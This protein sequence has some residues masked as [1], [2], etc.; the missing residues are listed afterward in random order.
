[1]EQG[2]GSTTGSGNCAYIFT[3]HLAT[4]TGGAN[5]AT[6]R[7]L[8]NTFGSTNSSPQVRAHRLARQSRPHLLEQAL[9]KPS[10]HI[11]ESN[12]SFPVTPALLKFSLNVTSWNWSSANL[13]LIIGA[14]IAIPL[15]CGLIVVIIALVS[16]WL[17]HQRR[18]AQANSRGA[19]SLD[20]PRASGDQL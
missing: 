5:N 9:S 12:Y 11:V 1:M 17:V 16:V 6:L 7:Y 14:A 8:F 10:T 18:A 20:D 2:N 3:S 4:A 19:V 15:A 13:D